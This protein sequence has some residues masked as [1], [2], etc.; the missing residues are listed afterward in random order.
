MFIF[1]PLLCPP[2]HY[3]ITA[4]FIEFH[5]SYVLGYDTDVGETRLGST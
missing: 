4:W 5:D 3:Y 1:S 2:M